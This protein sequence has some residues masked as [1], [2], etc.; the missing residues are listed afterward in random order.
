[1]QALGTVIEPELKRDLVSLNMVKDLTVEDGVARF[2]IV[3]TTP[4]CP[5]KDVMEAESR[6]AVLKVEGMRCKAHGIR[7]KAQGTRRKV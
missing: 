2:T 7:P 3:L 5:L 6:E 4:A 1:M